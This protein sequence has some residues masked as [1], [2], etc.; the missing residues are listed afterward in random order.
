MTAVIE[1]WMLEGINFCLVLRML[2]SRFAYILF[3]IC[4]P[5]RFRPSLSQTGLS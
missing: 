1:K 5:A 2:L 4:W 3:W